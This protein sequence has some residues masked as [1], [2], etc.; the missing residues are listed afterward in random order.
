MRVSLTPE[1]KAS[2]R[3]EHSWLARTE[4]INGLRT[5]TAEVLPVLTSW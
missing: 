1:L 4:G 3:R 5:F 2:P